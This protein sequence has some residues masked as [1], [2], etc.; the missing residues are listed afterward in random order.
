MRVYK[1]PKSQEQVHIS[2]EPLPQTYTQYFLYSIF[3]IKLSSKMQKKAKVLQKS[4]FRTAAMNTKSAALIQ[5][6]GGFINPFTGETLFNPQR[7]RTR[8]PGKIT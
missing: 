1:K 8:D 7:K 6:Q 2:A 5:E 4:L 3:N